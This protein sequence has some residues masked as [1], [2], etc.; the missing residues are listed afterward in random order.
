MTDRQVCCVLGSLALASAV[1]AVV[2]GAETVPIINS[3][4]TFTDALNDASV[5]RVDPTTPG[6]PLPLLVGQGVTD[7][8]G[9]SFA[10]WETPTPL[11]DPY[12]GVVSDAPGSTLVRVQLVFNGHVNPPGPAGLGGESFNPFKFGLKPVFGFIEIDLDADYDTGGE[13]GTA[14]ESRSLGAIGRF[15]GLA[16]ATRRDRQARSGA[17]IDRNFFTGPFYERSGADWLVGFCGC[18]DVTLISERSGD[19]DS[20]FESGEVWIVEGRFFRRAGGYQLGSLMFGG[21]APGLY[22]PPV[23]ALIHSDPGLTGTT[24]DDRTYFTI[25]YPLTMAGA[26]AL[27]GGA[28]EPIDTDVE[29]HTSIEEAIEDIII[30]AN[31]GGLTGP[32]QVLQQGWAGRSRG[33]ALTPGT[34]RASAL[35]GT[36]YPTQGSFT[37]IWT[38][39]GFDLK[40]G[41]MNGD[42]AAN[43]TDQNIIE[44]YITA[45]D[46]TAND[47]DGALNGSVRIPSYAVG[48]NYRDLNA[49]GLINFT[50]R[51][52]PL[53]PPLVVSPIGDLDGNGLVGLSDIA[54]VIAA[55]GEEGT[56]SPAD[57]NDDGVVDLADLAVVI[58]NWGGT[59][60]GPVDAIPADRRLASPVH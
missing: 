2:R 11:T 20:V 48:F 56:D 38:D 44:S 57:A 51:N 40:R 18:Y 16:G 33:I 1:G 35:L 41:D 43:V 13:T 5:H 21:T 10:A 31:A 34:W 26:A 36:V 12:S 46:G 23:R 19:G 29:N 7:L 15:G 53:Y 52:D 37:Y 22:D 50:D 42:G 55:W 9:V 28:E 24:D 32:T 4:V 49:D 59:S 45:N 3:S 58:Q 39:V 30:V 14:A 54:L 47:A 25:I 8:A 27:T 60:T 17:D 6:S